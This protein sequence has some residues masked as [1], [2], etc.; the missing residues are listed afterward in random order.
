MTGWNLLALMQSTGE[1][2][3]FVPPTESAPGSC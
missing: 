2:E 1:P 3:P